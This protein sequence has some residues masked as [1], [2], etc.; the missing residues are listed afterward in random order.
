[1]L[2]NLTEKVNSLIQHE[3]KQVVALLK[4]V[5][6]IKDQTK[7]ADR[8]IWVRALKYEKR[9]SDQREELQ[10]DYWCKQLWNLGLIQ[11]S[12]K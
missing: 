12:N 8:K 10:K 2:W 6:F 5:N 1:M 9:V 11:S 7:I 3:G 4:I